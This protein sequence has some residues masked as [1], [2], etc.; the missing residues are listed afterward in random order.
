MRQ[1]GEFH[2]PSRPSPIKNHG[3]FVALLFTFGCEG[4]RVKD[5]S[6]SLFRA[7]F[8]IRHNDGSFHRLSPLC[9]D[10]V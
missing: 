8:W 7:T 2:W 10:G 3:H 4:K 5:S 6:G 1:F 9:I